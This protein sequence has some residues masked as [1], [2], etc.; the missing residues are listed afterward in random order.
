MRTRVAAVAIQ[1]VEEKA[2]L[3]GVRTPEEEAHRI[4]LAVAEVLRQAQGL[5]AAVAVAAEAEAVG[6]PLRP[7]HSPAQPR[8][9]RPEAVH[10]Y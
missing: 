6:V 2:I 1:A 4:P 8:H 9:L 7:E 5:Q 10:Q 3:A